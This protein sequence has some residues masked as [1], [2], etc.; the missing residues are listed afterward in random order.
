VPPAPDCV[1]PL[2]S[3]PPATTDPATGLRLPYDQLPM[4]IRTLFVGYALIALGTG[5]PI[6]SVIVAGTIASWNGCTLN[7]GSAHPC[8]VNGADIGGTLYA[9]GVMGWFMIATIPLGFIATIV[10][11]LAWVVVARMRRQKTG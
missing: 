6:A 10:W 5:W 2:A 4:T 11:T 8:V 7:E 9:M 3:P 1:I